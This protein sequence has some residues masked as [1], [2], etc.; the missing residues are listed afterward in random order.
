MMQIDHIDVNMVRVTKKSA[1]TGN[2]NSMIIPLR[3][4]EIE[5]WLNSSMLVQDAFPWIAAEV[6]EFLVSGITPEEWD[7]TFGS[8][9]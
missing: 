6:R 9:V 8:D 3:Q 7:A 2:H 1:L 4:G 5:H